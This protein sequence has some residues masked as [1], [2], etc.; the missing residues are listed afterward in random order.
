MIY[1]DI[2]SAEYCLLVTSSN[3]GSVYAN[4]YKKYSDYIQKDGDYGQ[5]FSMWRQCLY[6][7]LL[8]KMIGIPGT[9]L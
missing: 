2:D 6:V 4:L 7:Q 3:A 1:N 5:V 9:L 8:K